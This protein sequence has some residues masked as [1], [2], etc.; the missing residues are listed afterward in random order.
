[1]KAAYPVRKACPACGKP[2]RL[3]ADE[4]GHK[5][6]VC[7]TCDDPFQDAAARRWMDSPLTPPE[8]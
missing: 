8:K 4:K 7:T 3:V 6:Y 5:Q 2:M 1:M